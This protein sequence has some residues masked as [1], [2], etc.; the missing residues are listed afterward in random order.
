[1]G[2]E[3]ETHTR[4]AHLFR[5]NVVSL[6]RLSGSLAKNDNDVSFRCKQN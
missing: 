6:Q 5:V 1:M 3:Q 2:R 4:M